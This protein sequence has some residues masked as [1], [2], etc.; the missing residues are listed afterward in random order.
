MQQKHLYNKLHQRVRGVIST[1]GP[2]QQTG[3]EQKGRFKP[4]MQ[5]PGITIE[6]EKIQPVYSL[7]VKIYRGGVFWYHK[8]DLR[9]LDARSIS[10]CSR[11]AKTKREQPLTQCRE[12]LKTRGKL[13]KFGSQ[14][15]K[16]TS[17]VFNPP[18]PP[19][20]LQYRHAETRVNLGT[21][22]NHVLLKHTK[23]F[24]HCHF[25]R[26]RQIPALCSWRGGG[27]EGKKK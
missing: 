13:R 17:A 11:S 15:K 4:N 8:I 18:P 16:S 6:K 25:P 9:D 12:A 10:C 2:S 23:P 27:G 21:A 3:R 26:K 14:W 7:T 22:E 20:Q 19:P 5:D 24:L 1:A